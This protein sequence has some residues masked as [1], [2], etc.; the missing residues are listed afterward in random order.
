MLTNDYNI[1]DKPYIT[2]YS[3]YNFIFNG[4]FWLYTLFYAEAYNAPWR[5][6]KN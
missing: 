3:E 5:G 2:V 4:E 6:G 1:R